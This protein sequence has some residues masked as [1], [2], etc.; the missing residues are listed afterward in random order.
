MG[1]GFAKRKIAQEEQHDK[2]SAAAA[3]YANDARRTQELAKMM[4]KAEDLE[5]RLSEYRGHNIAADDAQASAAEAASMCSEHA[6]RNPTT[7]RWS[8]PLLV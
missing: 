2:G 7:R 3:A 5:H 4:N 1:V 6:P 8:F